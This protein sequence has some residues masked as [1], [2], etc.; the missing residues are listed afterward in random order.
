MLCRDTDDELIHANMLLEE[1]HHLANGTTPK[2]AVGLCVGPVYSGAPTFLG[3]YPPP[4]MACVLLGTAPI[5][6]VCYAFTAHPWSKT[7]SVV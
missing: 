5:L 1:I 7:G 3:T 2:K 6:R 4:Y